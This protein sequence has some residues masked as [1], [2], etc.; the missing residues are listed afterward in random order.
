MNL[1]KN[2]RCTRGYEMPTNLQNL[3][4]KDLT[5]VKNSKKFF[6]GEATFLNTL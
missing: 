4:Q 3:T 1:Q 5:E 6:L 2:G